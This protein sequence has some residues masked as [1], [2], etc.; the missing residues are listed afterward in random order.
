M[1]RVYN[2]MLGV[3]YPYEEYA[4]V[5]VRDFTAGGMEHISAT[6]MTDTRFPDERSEEDYTSTYSRPDRTVR[7][8]VAHELVHQWFGD[9]VTTID[10]PHA[11]L[12]EGFATYY[13]A[14][15]VEVAKGV[16]E[17][18]QD[19]AYKAAAHIDEDENRYRRAIVER[20]YVNPEDLFDTVLYEKAGW[21]LHQLRFILG[22]E[23]A[24]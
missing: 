24:A 4:Q 16:N 15:Y 17:F 14:L 6:T 10:W 12:N 13:A 21:M 23:C 19:L 20:S 5:T 22:D 8:L 2:K 11:W 18:R 9:L 1:L 7:D 3:P